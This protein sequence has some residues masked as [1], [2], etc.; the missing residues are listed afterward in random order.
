MKPRK[1]SDFYLI[2]NK[3][4]ETFRTFWEKTVGTANNNSALRVR[5]KIKGVPIHISNKSSIIPTLKIRGGRSFYKENRFSLTQKWISGKKRE[6]SA[7]KNLFSHGGNFILSFEI[8]TVSV[9][10]LSNIFYFS[11]L[12]QPCP[13]YGKP[14]RQFLRK[15]LFGRYKALLWRNI[16]RPRKE[17]RKDQALL[18]R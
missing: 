6:S 5:K 9:L 10:F 8:I 18:S 12:I 17:K 4:R 13:F 3:T 7:I 15:V 2:E 16:Y 11:V 14:A 1:S